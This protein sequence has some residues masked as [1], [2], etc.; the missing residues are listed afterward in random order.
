[1]YNPSGYILQANYSKEMYNLIGSM[2][3]VKNI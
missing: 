3:C 1:M 2:V